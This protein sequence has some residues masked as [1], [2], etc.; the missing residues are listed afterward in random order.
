MRLSSIHFLSICNVSV[1]WSAGRARV[2]DPADDD[3]VELHVRRDDEL[4]A[5]PA[6]LQRDPVGRLPRQRVVVDRDRETEQQHD[7]DKETDPLQSPS[8]AQPAL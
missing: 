2:A 8:D 5:D 4:V 1:V 7:D 6:D 3:A